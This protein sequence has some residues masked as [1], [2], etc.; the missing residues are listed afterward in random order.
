MKELQENLIDRIE[1]IKMAKK[2]LGICAFFYP[3]QMESP[4]HCFLGSD[5]PCRTAALKL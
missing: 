2:A 1:S 4:A 3:C 5:A